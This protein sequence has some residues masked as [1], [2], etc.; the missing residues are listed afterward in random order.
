MTRPGGMILLRSLALCGVLLLLI[1]GCG[2]K[3]NPTMKSFDKP[4]P[5]K[6][7]RAVHSD[8]KITLSWSYSKQAK[9]LVKGFYIERAVGFGT[10][11]NI[12]FVPA[13]TSRYDDQRFEINKEYHY[14]I[15]VYSMRNVISDGS[16][17]LNVTAVKLPD[18]PKHMSYRL[19]ND[20]VEI[21]WDKAPEGVTFN[22]YKSAEK[23][24][25][26][27][28]PL[29][30]APLDKPFFRDGVDVGAP[31]FYSVRSI[32]E[33]NILNEGDLSND[34]E[35]DPASFV[36]ASPQDMRYVRAENKLYLSWRENPESWI[37][38]YKV[39]KKGA[40][41]QYTPVAEVNIPLFIDEG[42]IREGTSYYITA[43]GPVKESAPSQAV[44]IKP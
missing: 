14:R 43:L 19:T 38:G 11:D 29:N 27:G 25:Y 37:H 20:A 2:K 31:V 21:S 5:A 34:L 13:D 18:A 32:V 41:G 35:I 28:A 33:S 9:I 39:Y 16:A 10:F 15:R 3:G 1:S 7:L 30:A 12:A 8:N 24:K 17:E 4:E 40:E 22:I 42:T 23:G 44:S 26:S 6:D 36:P